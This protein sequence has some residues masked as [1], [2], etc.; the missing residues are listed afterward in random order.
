MGENRPH[1]NGPSTRVVVAAVSLV[2]TLL[3]GC[4]HL[5]ARQ[6]ATTGP[7][8][9]YEYWGDNLDSAT[10]KATSYCRS[11]G[12]YGAHLISVTQDGDRYRATFE[13]Q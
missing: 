10:Q 11:I 2:L 4:T 9:S 7:T 3:A 6:V 8:V 13:C 5:G 1:E 12:T